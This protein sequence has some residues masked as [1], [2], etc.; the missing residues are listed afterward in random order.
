LEFAC[1][2]GYP[3]GLLDELPASCVEAFTGVS[4]VSV[5]AEIAPG[6]TVL[7]LGC[8]AGLDSLIAARKTGV[9]GKV[10]GIDFSAAMLGRA[11]TA[12]SALG[13]S[14][15]EFRKG[16]AELIPLEDGS[17]DAAMV[18]GIFNLNPARKNIHSEL[19][20]V[21][22]PGGTAWA[23]ELVLRGPLPEDESRS[24]ADWFA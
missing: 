3:A 21:L 20:R 19:S 14:Q 7:D 4:N 23:A 9:E 10:V 16:N 12:A 11:R 5:I 13:L 6:S 2:L 15:V 17:I 24:D 18:N 22:R 1:S 8:G